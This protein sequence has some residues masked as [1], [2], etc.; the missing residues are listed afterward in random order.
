MKRLSTNPLLETNMSD[1]IK[2]E[3][4]ALMSHA[5]GPSPLE[6][7]MGAL[8]TGVDFES[9]TIYLVGEVEDTTSFKFL[10]GFR[11]LDEEEEPI[12][13]VMN[14]VGG[15]ESDGYAIHDTIK[16]SRNMVQIEAYG[17]C[18]SI[19]AAIMQAGDLR[20]MAPESSFMIHNGS[21]A[22]HGGIEQDKVVR[23]AN[24]IAEESLRYYRI[25]S[26]RSGLDLDTVAKLCMA[27]TFLD[28]KAAV[29]HG[30]VDAVI[31]PGKVRAK[32]RKKK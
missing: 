23:I 14:S 13:I 8:A 4:Q 28:A 5:Q 3:L 19:A 11:T 16:L 15:S 24:H 12:R 29:K 18:L 10:V 7:T 26:E 31:K 22:I 6:R 9:R 1:D 27:E 32:R 17:A 20:L 21:M 25:L 30:F 2:N